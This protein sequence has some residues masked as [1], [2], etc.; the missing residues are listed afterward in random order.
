VYAGTPG[1]IGIRRVYVASGV[2]GAFV[3]VIDE[4]YLEA[5]LGTYPSAVQRAYID[6][7][8]Y[9]PNTPE[10]VG[11]CA[12]GANGKI[13]IGNRSGFTAGALY[14]ADSRGKMIYSNGKWLFAQG[15]FV[16]NVNVLRFSGNGGTLENTEVVAIGDVFSIGIYSVNASAI[17]YIVADGIYLYKSEDTGDSYSQIELADVLRNPIFIAPDGYMMGTWDGSR[18]GRASDGI[19]WTDIG[20]LPAV[21]PFQYL[22]AYCGGSSTSSRWIA[23][24]AYLLYSA[25]FGSNWDDRQ[26]NLPFIIPFFEIAYIAVPGFYQ[27]S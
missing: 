15:T 9:N 8:T 26:G 11:F 10:Q 16:G 14:S 7:I 3:K 21:I 22:Y 12:N 23:G 6:A 5:E 4:D 17:S 27:G 18:K 20:S 2:G 24:Y 25:D 1:L 19:S 13:F